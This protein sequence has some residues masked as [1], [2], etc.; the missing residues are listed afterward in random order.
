MSPVALTP[1][2]SAPKD[3][4]DHSPSGDDV[5]NVWSHITTPHVTMAWCLIDYRDNATFT[6]YLQI[7]CGWEYGEI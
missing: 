7:L 4:A 5:K 2:I 6:P 1:E 3:E